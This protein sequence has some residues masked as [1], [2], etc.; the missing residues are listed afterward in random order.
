MPPVPESIAQ[1]CKGLYPILLAGDVDAFAR[2]LSQWEDVIGDTAELTTTSEAQ[3]RRTMTAL[4]RHPKQFNLPPWPRTPPEVDAAGRENRTPLLPAR[5]PWSDS[6]APPA[7][8]PPVAREI[9]P[10]ANEDEIEQ[11]ETETQSE[12]FQLDMLTGEF[13]PVERGASRAHHEEL[14]EQKEAPRRRKR[15]PRRS[16]RTDLVQLSLLDAEASTA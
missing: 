13:V 6:P 9:P 12:V 1:F 14:P 5:H 3:Q 11:K 2:Y 16:P 4:L 8:P 7:P 15:Q 10:R